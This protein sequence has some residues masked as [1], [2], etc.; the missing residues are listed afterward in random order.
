MNC[1]FKTYL[2]NKKSY[3]PTCPPFIRLFIP[4]C[5]S[6]FPSDTGFH[7]SE[8]LFDGSYGGVDLVV[9]SFTFCI[10]EKYFTCN[11]GIYFHWVYNS[12]LT[13]FSPLYFED[14]LHSLLTCIVSDKTSA[15]ILIF[16]FSV[17]NVFFSS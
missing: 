9:N 3:F 14:S 4:F 7:P 11:S 8:G 2:K 6:T 1:L 13:S 16:F 15:V 12:A 10:S 17:Y 5:R